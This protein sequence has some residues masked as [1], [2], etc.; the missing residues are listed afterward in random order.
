MHYWNEEEMKPLVVELQSIEDWTT[1][2]ARQLLNQL[3]PGIKKIVE[4]EVMVHSFWRWDNV[5]DLIQTG[6]EACIKSIRKFNPDYIT[7]KGE[8]VKCFNYFSL[9]AKRVMIYST[10]HNAP[11]RCNGQLDETF[12]RKNVDYKDST[13]EGINNF[14]DKVRVIDFSRDLNGLKETLLLYVGTCGKFNKR[15]FFRFARTMGHSTTKCRKFLKEFM[16]YKDFFY[17]GVD[18]SVDSGCYE[19][20]EHV[21]DEF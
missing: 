7:S 14:L 10:M 17:E 9:T 15:E 3:A 19:E 20:K 16:E 11:H 5:E 4:A 21:T 6:L 13:T 18:E 12:T 1:P 2:R 8:V